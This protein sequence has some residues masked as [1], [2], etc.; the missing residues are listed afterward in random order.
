MINVNQEMRRLMRLNKKQLVALLKETGK[1]ANA[2][3]KARKQS[4]DWE[5]LPMET[6]RVIKGWTNGNRGFFHVSMPKQKRTL[7][8]ELAMWIIHNKAFME[9]RKPLQDDDRTPEGLD[10]IPIEDK[11]KWFDSDFW[12]IYWDNYRDKMSKDAYYAIGKRVV[13]ECETQGEFLARML[14]GEWI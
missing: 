4:G 7:K 10:D 1:A 11:T 8:K 3:L 2:R 6:R 14:N 5:R 13:E 12:T 9:V